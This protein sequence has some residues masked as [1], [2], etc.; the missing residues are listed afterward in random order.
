M[1][2]VKCFFSKFAPGIAP[3]ATSTGDL[4]RDAPG[5]SA[6]RRLD[7]GDGKRARAR[8]GAVAGA[9]AA[10]RGLLH[11]AA[12]PGSARSPRFHPTRTTEAATHP[13]GAGVEARAPPRRGASMPAYSLPPPQPQRRPP[14]R[15]RRT[16]PPRAGASASSACWVA[17]LRTA[18]TTSRRGCP[19]CG[20]TRIP[21]VP[22]LGVGGGV[23]DACAAP[24]PPPLADNA[25]PLRVCDRPSRVGCGRTSAC[26]WRAGTS[27][28]LRPSTR[29]RW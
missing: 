18:V 21:W 16:H 25:R 24:T 7:D 11:R 29:R 6:R 13:R 2:P 3:P 28:P 4:A 12:A 23:A 15:R 14:F 27:P 26:G 19:C 8:P 10:S 17:P 22:A 1:E 20:Y 9:P 5:L